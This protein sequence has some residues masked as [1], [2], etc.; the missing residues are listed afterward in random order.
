MTFPVTMNWNLAGGMWIVLA[1]VGI[2]VLP[3]ARRW[4][5][6]LLAWLAGLVSLAAVGWPVCGARQQCPT[7]S[8]KGS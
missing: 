7:R 6:S 2:M 8:Q 4:P 5:F 3:E 1:M